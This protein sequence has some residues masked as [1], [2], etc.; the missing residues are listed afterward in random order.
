MGG[1]LEGRQFVFVPEEMPQ[2]AISIVG[3]NREEFQQQIDKV[4]A[5][6]V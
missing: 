5:D 4:H 2:D 1:V 3:R 6:G